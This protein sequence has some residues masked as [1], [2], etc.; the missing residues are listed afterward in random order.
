MRRRR[1]WSSR[2]RRARARRRRRRRARPRAACSGPTRPLAGRRARGVGRGLRDA[3][4][5]ARPVRPP[6]RYAAAAVAGIV[7]AV[8]SPGRSCACR[9][10]W[11]SPCSRARRR[12]SRCRSARRRRTCSCRCTSSSSPRRSRSRG[13][14]SVRTARRAS[15]ARSP[16]RSRSSSAG[17]GSPSSGRS[18]AGRARSTCSSSC[19]RSGLLAVSLARLP[20]RPAG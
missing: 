9:G 12:G 19:S 14:S 11:R 15:S 3:R 10:C 5:L 17:P 4:G 18:T 6:P 1:W 20:W 8:G 7:L 13:S 16:G 2:D